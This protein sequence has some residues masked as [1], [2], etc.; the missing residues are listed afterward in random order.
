MVAKL[1]EQMAAKGLI[2][3]WRGGDI[4]K[5]GAIPFILGIYEYQ[6]KSMDEDFARMFEEYLQEAFHKNLAELRPS[7]LRTIP[8][9][10]SV[11]ATYP[12]AP[13]E[14]SREI[15]LKQSLIAVTNCICRVQQRLVGNQCTKP[16]EVCFSFGSAACYYIDQGMGREIDHEEALA[17]LDR[18][19]EAGLVAQPGNIQN[20][21]GMCNC[22]G[23][24]CPTLRM[25]KRYPRPAALIVSN[26]YAVLDQKG[27]SGCQ[28]CI[29]RCQMEAITINDEGVAQIDLN[30][31]IGCG[32]CALTC[33]TEAI[34]LKV[35]PEG[36][37]LI[38]PEKG[39]DLMEEMARRRGKSLLPFTWQNK[40][41]AQ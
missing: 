27:C 28:T 22:C 9:N 40:P 32:L 7:I 6:L 29:G 36:Q 11:V 21:G 39:R 35:K 8:I 23:D 34:T 38:P 1:L 41:P 33:P 16:L 17:I 14:D 5:Y 24:C 26:Y 20:P 2:F 37:R 25:A 18:C 31:C 13:Y 30:R 10:R 3:R 15:I 19:Q 4:T 12:V